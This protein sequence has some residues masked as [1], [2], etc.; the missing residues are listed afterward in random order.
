MKYWQLK[1]L[2]TDWK[3]KYLIKKYHEG[4]KI[5][6]HE[7]KSAAEK[8]IA[9]LISYQHQPEKILKWIHEF[10]HPGLANRMKQTIRARRKRHFNAK[11]QHTRKKSIDLEYLVWQQL[12]ALAIRRGFTLSE[13]IISLLEDAEC[14][15]KYNKTISWLR[16]DLQTILSEQKK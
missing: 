5:T 10:M 1:N 4:D 7:K 3:W 2:E 12:S 15:E 13:T 16:H 11:H 14:K 9:T 6:W 8:S